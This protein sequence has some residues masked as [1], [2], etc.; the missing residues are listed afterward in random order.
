MKKPQTPLLAVDGV[1]RLWKETTFRGIVLIERLY[2]PYGFALPGG[3][4]QIGETVEEAVIREIKEETGLD[5]SI[6]K[7]LGVYSHP[8]RDPRFH[9]ASVVFILDAEGSPSAGDD[10]KKV[11]IFKLED[12]PFDK[13]VFDHGSILWD[14]IRS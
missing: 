8:N 9:V 4:V 5:A 12:I 6:R 7:L 11:H 1:V 14:F 2:P 10:A 13:L 3:F